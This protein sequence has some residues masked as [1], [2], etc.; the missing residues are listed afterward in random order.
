MDIAKYLS[1]TELQEQIR[2]NWQ[3]WGNKINQRLS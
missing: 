2:A 1:R 3:W